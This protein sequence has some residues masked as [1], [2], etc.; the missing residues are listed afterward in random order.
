[1]RGTIASSVDRYRQGRAEMQKKREMRDGGRVI[2]EYYRQEKAEMQ[3][4]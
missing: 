1:M 4:Y 3:R 2:C